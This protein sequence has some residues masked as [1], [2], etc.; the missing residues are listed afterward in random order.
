[1]RVVFERHEPRRY[2]SLVHRDDGVVLLLPGYDRKYR[3]PHD[4]AHFAVERE[5]RL[6]GGVWGT[7][8]A[9]GVFPNMQVVSGRT[10]HDARQRSER[11]IRENRH[12]L[13]TAEILAGVVHDAVERGDRGELCQRARGA[14]GVLNEEPFPYPDEALTA[15]ADTLEDLAARWTGRTF[16]VEWGQ[17]PRAMRRTS[18]ASSS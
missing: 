16:E 17:P 18:R 10:K 12:E 11:V 15:A 8:A 4:L 7:I 5:L 1:M 6:T 9:G 13:G 2:R 14:W 3:V